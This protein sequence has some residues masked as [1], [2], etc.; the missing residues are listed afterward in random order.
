MRLLEKSSLEREG[1]SEAGEGELK[2]MEGF[3][4]LPGMSPPHPPP[5]QG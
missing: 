2:G 3:D 5:R 4:G 1:G